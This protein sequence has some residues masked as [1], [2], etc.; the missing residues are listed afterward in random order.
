MTPEV[1][2]RVYAHFRQATGLEPTM[3]FPGAGGYWW[4]LVQRDTVAAALRSM[5]AAAPDELVSVIASGPLAREL[6]R[7]EAVPS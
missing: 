7:L 5:Q 6:D 4:R 1:I 3:L 2:E